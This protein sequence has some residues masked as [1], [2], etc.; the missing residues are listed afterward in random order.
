M[1]TYFSSKV[2]HLR[3]SFHFLKKFLIELCF[4][5]WMIR[6]SIFLLIASKKNV[7]SCHPHG[8]PYQVT[9]QL[10]GGWPVILL[11][12]LILLSCK[13]VSANWLILYIFYRRIML[14]LVTCTS[15]IIRERFTMCTDVHLKRFCVHENSCT[16]NYNLRRP[17][18]TEKYYKD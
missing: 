3:L 6:L 12:I 5:H 11:L 2:I 7:Q 8:L 4:S 14:L 9:S 16:K 17:G 15:A 13:K 1:K 10:D 18:N